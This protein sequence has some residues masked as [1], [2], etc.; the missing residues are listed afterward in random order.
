MQSIV[1]RSPGGPE[2]LELV[3]HPT[4]VP[5]PGQV[6]IRVVS[7]GVNFSDV[8]RRR[9]DDYPFPTAFPYTPG[10]EVAG[11]VEA[12]GEGVRAPELGT[13]VF[14]LVGGDG[15]TGY[16]QYALAEAAQ[17]VPVP[18]D[19]DSD[20]AAGL[21][22]AG[23][24]AMLALVDVMD[25]QPGQRVLVEAAGGGV[26]AHAVQIAAHLGAEVVALASTP[27]KRASALV[28]GATQAIDPTAPGWADQLGGPV[29]AVLHSAGPS[30]FATELGL[31]APFGTMVVIGNAEGVPLRIE[32]GTVTD[33]LYAP[34][35]NKRLVA[36]NVGLFFGLR[37]DRARAALGRLVGLVR[38]GVVTPRVGHVLPLSEA[39]QAHRLL[40]SRRS[41]GRIVLKPWS[42]A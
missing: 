42:A 23:S 36:F 14:A 28:A 38:A 27:D 3:E 33:L 8:K 18:G 20:V 9:D 39:A 2:V 17:T 30:T 10:G 6:L 22:I 21:I 7:A 37:P 25:L 35:L 40:E 4:P 1:A 34:A 32:E 24:T 16:A 11:T 19:L 13:R 12:L 26:G 29:D 5:G 15:S 41:H 31:L